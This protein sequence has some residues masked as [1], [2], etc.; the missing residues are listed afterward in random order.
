MKVSHYCIGF[1]AKQE[2]LP[3]SERFSHHKF[4]HAEGNL[5]IQE[6]TVNLIFLFFTNNIFHFDQI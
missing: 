2:L 5:G 1:R 3:Y 4:H 6:M